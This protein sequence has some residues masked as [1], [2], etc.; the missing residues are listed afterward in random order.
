V[1]TLVQ[2]AGRVVRGPGDWGE[3]LV[4]DD[5]VLDL[6]RRHGAMFPHWFREAF[7]SVAEVPPPMR[8]E[9]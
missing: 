9:L 2:M 7:T 8:V 6:Y 3:T 1:T 4:I 5:H